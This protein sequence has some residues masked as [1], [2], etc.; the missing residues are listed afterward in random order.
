MTE[1]PTCTG[2]SLR[3]GSGCDDDRER[4]VRLL[5]RDGG[6][7]VVA[8]TGD[9]RSAVRLSGQVD[10][11]VVLLELDLPEVNAIDA[12]AAIIHTVPE[13]TVVVLVPRGGESGGDLAVRF[14]APGVVGRDARR[15]LI[16]APRSGDGRPGVHPRHA[17]RGGSF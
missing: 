16:E 2:W 4:I 1:S 13:T 6:Y 8:E 7:D 11:E 5:D 10:P 17:K 3:P 9:G 12:T 15:P 14:G